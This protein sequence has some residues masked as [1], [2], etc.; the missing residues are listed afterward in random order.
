M[1]LFLLE[2]LKKQLHHKSKP[3]LL[4]YRSGTQRNSGL[5]R[6]NEIEYLTNISSY[7]FC[8]YWYQK[9]KIF[10]TLAY[11]DTIFHIRTYVSTYLLIHMYTHLIT[12]QENNLQFYIT[13]T[14]LGLG[15]LLFWFWLVSFLDK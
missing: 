3:Y 2:I 10:D 5:V 12:N 6:V 14:K 11:N 4:M 15:F 13:L 1:N 9:L 7:L 8:S